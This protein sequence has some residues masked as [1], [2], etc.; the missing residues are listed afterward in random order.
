MFDPLA[1][2]SLHQD[3]PTDGSDALR[4]S[5]SA[6]PRPLRRELHQRGRNLGVGIGCFAVEL[7][8]RL[9]WPQS[10]SR[11]IATPR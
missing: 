4:H 3:P 9:R 7:A 1:M 5:T 11:V 10:P 2:I 6:E 8:R